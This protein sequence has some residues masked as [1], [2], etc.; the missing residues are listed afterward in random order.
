MGAVI[1]AAS[2]GQITTGN[3]NCY[4][5]PSDKVARIIKCTLTNDA[6]SPVTISM[7]KVPYGYSPSTPKL[8]MNSK[9]IGSEET[10][11]CPEIV[12]QVFNSLMWLNGI[13]SVGYQLTISLDVVEITY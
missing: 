2:L 1:K 11:E 4:Q 6:T 8:L 9:I 10:Y 5:C 7:H 12:G 13:A 3:T